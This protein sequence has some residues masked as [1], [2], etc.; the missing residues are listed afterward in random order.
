[1][2]RQKSI[3]IE[4]TND[5]RSKLESTL[6]KAKSEQRDVFRAQIILEASQGT[7]NRA[8]A[9][10][11]KT[12]RSIV[13]EWRKRFAQDRLKGLEDKPRSGRPSTFSL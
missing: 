6:R 8:I 7:S 12:T 2:P 11:L 3:P 13:L 5:E 1:M 9:K 10:K 4:L